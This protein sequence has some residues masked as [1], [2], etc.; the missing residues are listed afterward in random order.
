MNTLAFR[1]LHCKPLMD[2]FGLR[3]SRLDPSAAGTQQHEVVA[4]SPSAGDWLRRAGHEA[5]RIHKRMRNTY[6]SEACPMCLPSPSCS[7]FEY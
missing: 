3:T 4:R 5:D 1:N 6:K 2:A 7:M